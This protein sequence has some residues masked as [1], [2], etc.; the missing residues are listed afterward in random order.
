MIQGNKPSGYFT[1]IDQFGRKIEGE[2]RMCAHC[3]HSW[4]YK[5]GSGVRRGYCRRCNGMLCGSI[6][7]MTYCI[8]YEHRIE[9]IEKGMNWNE[10][11]NH[12]FNKYDSKIF[13]TT[14]TL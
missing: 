1:A 3:Q 2:K 6:S 8:P 5:K 7:C 13:K 11:L 9:A 10:L 4:I 12:Q 14:E